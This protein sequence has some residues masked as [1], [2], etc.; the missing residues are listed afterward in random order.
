MVALWRLQPKQ[1]AKQP[2]AKPRKARR[3]DLQPGSELYG[4]AFE[5]RVFYEL[6]AHNSYSNASAKLSDWR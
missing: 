5:N 2:E 1:R 3:G 6:C 4:E